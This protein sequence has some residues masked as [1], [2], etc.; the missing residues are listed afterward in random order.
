MTAMTQ[1]PEALL[2]LVRQLVRQELA[3][4]QG[5]MLA[6]VQDIHP[7]TYACTVRLQD[8]DTVL[9]KVPVASPRM[10]LAGIPAENH[11]VLVQFICGDINRPVITGSLYNDEDTPPTNDDGQLV[12]HLPLGAGDGEGVQLVVSSNDTATVK[13]QI[14]SGLTLLLQDDDPVVSLDVGDGSATL[15]IDSD[16]AVTLASQKDLT[17]EAGGDLKL[18]GTNIEAEASGDATI[19][20]S[21]INLN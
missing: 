3:A 10:G 1:H 18:K 2:Q 16:G 14:G 12:C 20:G 19:K 17:L 11:L 9:N 21:A 13:L 4:H 15:T 6:I 5:A 8:T 7:D